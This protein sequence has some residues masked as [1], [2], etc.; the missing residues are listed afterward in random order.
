MNEE[1]LKILKD[2]KKNVSPGQSLSSGCSDWNTYSK[3]L[4]A[5]G[6]E[7]I[8]DIEEKRASAHTIKLHLLY[9]RD[10][11]AMEDLDEFY[12][13][14]CKDY[15]LFFDASMRLINIVFEDG[16]SGG[17]SVKCLLEHSSKAMDNMGTL[18]SKKSTEY[19]HCQTLFVALI[20]IIIASISTIFSLLALLWRP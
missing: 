1:T 14:L 15:E 6:S 4:I 19:K 20:A 18:V 8:K 3:A 13:Q 5:A 2:I 7:I 17:D 12:H 11:A 9:F 16:R 10:K